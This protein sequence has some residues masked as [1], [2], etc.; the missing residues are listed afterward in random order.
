MTESN[1]PR[2]ATLILAFG[3]VYLVWGSTYWAIRVGLDSVPPFLLGAIRFAVAGGLLLAYAW[4]VDRS[5]PTRSHW[6]AAT[7]TGVL[8]LLMGNGAVMLAE[9]RA[10]SGLVALV[11]TTVPIW[12]VL[13]DWLR[14]GGRRPALAVFLGLA[15][16]TWGIA[17]LVDPTPAPGQ[18]AVPPFEVAVLLIGTIAWAIG[19]LSSRSG[20]APGPATLLAALQMLVASAA[21]AGVAAGTGEFSSFDA[22]RVAPRSWLAIAYLAI[23]GSVV[24]YSAY[25]WLVRVTTPAKV[26]TYAYVNPVVALALGA[27][28]GGEAIT[29]RVITAAVLLLG[30]VVLINAVGLRRTTPV[31]SGRGAGEAARRASEL[32]SRT[33][34]RH[35]A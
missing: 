14:P 29:P 33:E 25:V 27:A 5:R 35:A 34:Q 3:L 20:R 32:L 21:F 1:R 11:V 13:L 6:R 15:L 18:A 4:F 19:S 17:L 26:S 22:A 10:P 24:A 31:P 7:L 9:R 16:G 30:A 23:F 8:M 28:L 2:P 12:M